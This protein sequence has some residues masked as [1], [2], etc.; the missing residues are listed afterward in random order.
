MLSSRV[1][2]STVLK[3]RLSGFEE[4]LNIDIHDNY[5][6]IMKLSYPNFSYPVVGCW[7]CLLHMVMHSYLPQVAM[8]KEV[9]GSVSPRPL[10]SHIHVSET[11]PS[12]PPEGSGKKNSKLVSRRSHSSI[13]YNRMADGNSPSPVA[14]AQANPQTGGCGVL[15]GCG[16]YLVR[17]VGG[18]Q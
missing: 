12:P 17:F 9:S 11:E 5:F 16:F 8:R 10:S 3:D 14:T 1:L 6:N 15:G 4:W 13:G 2:Y 18:A 7:P